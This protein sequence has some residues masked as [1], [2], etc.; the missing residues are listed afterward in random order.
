MVTLHDT[1]HRTSYLRFK[2][3][4]LTPIRSEIATDEDLKDTSLENDENEIKTENVTDSDHISVENVET[5]QQLE[6]DENEIDIKINNIDDGGDVNNLTGSEP[7]ALPITSTKCSQ[8]IQ[9]LEYDIILVERI[10]S[11]FYLML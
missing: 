8:D 5:S 4:I 3:L 9:V 1:I 11:K 7:A 10:K 2:M 6:H